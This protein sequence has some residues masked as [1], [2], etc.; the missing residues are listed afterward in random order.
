ME[1]GFL[2]GTLLRFRFSDK[3]VKG[4]AT[5]YSSASSR[6]LLPGAKGP[7]FRLTRSVR[8]GFPL[9]PFLFLFFA[10][11]LS[12]FLTARD[13]GVKGISLPLSILEEILDAE[14]ADDT[15]TTFS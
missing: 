3:W 1:W 8:Q 10:E 6:V 11:A 9:A 7:S 13:S 2:E 5:L 12:L 14:F 4:T 15:S